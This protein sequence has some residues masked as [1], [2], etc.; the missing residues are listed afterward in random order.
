[1]D[2]LF[3]S[4]SLNARSFNCPLCGAH[5]KFNWGDVFYN[6]HSNIVQVPG[7]RMANCD[8]C[9]NVVVFRESDI[10]FINFYGR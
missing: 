6:P 2:I 3:V 5:A 9:L 4:P 1:M 10:I 7:Y 8:H